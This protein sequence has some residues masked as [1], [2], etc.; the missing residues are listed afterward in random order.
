MQREWECGFQHKSFKCISTLV[1]DRRTSTV[2]F[3]SLPNQLEDFLSINH[4]D[5]NYC[6]H[7]VGFPIIETTC[8]HGGSTLCYFEI[9]RWKTWWIPSIPFHTSWI[10]SSLGVMIGQ[11]T[12]ENGRTGLEHVLCC[13]LWHVLLAAA[14]DAR[15]GMKMASILVAFLLLGSN[16]I[17]KSNWRKFVLTWVHNSNKCMAEGR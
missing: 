2:Y 13:L 14:R 6:G 17:S 12:W 10:V 8:F 1:S 5:A 11:D 4:E 15:V 9:F 3:T 16:T 7:F